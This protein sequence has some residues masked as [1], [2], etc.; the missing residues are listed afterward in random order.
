MLRQRTMP[1]LSLK[2]RWLQ[3]KTQRLKWAR[4]GKKMAENTEDACKLQIK[5]QKTEE[6]TIPACIILR[7][8]IC[9]CAYGMRSEHFGVGSSVSARA[10]VFARVGWAG[11][12]CVFKYATVGGKKTRRAPVFCFP[13]LKTVT[14]P[15]CRINDC[16]KRATPSGTLV[17]NPFPKYLLARA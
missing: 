15:H 10:C 17:Q 13:L 12:V 9:S 11:C 2:N 3:W 16:D 4:A 5:S 6:I 1:V 7:P 8:K 14:R